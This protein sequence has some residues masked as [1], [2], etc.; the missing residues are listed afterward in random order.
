MS[1]FCRYTFQDVHI[2]VEECPRD[3]CGLK[4][5]MVV[6]IQSVTCEVGCVIIYVC[7]ILVGYMITT[8]HDYYII[9]TD[10]YIEGCIVYNPI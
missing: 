9:T 8:L 7:Y 1:V 3:H 5:R 4:V 10:G 2:P 6:S